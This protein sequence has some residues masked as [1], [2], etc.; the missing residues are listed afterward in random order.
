MFPFFSRSVFYHFR[1]VS[2]PADFY[3]FVNEFIIFPLM[4]ISFSVSVNIKPSHTL[5]TAHVHG[6]RF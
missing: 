6:R 5:Y 3:V 2:I 4:D 1:F